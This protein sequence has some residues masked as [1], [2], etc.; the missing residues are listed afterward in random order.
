MNS[1]NPFSYPPRAVLKSVW[2]FLLPGVGLLLNAFMEQQNDP[3]DPVT[4]LDWIIAGLTCVVTGYTVFAVENKPPGN[5][6]PDEADREV[7]AVGFLFL[8]GVLLVAVAILGLLGVVNLGLV[9]CLILAIIGVVL[10]VV[11]R[12]G[13]F[14]A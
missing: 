6:T 1:W 13:R 8:I 12:T 10:M 3:T 5:V 14:R 7:G 11:D 9:V 2:G 4:V